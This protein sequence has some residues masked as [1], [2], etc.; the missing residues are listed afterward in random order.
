MEIAVQLE[1]QQKDAGA[2]QCT[3]RGARE[4]S[5]VLRILPYQPEHPRHDHQSRELSELHADV[6]CQNAGDEALFRK[7]ELLQSGGKPESVNKAEPKHHGESV[8][9]ADADSFTEAVEIVEAL[10]DHRQGDHSVD[11][12]VVGL[13]GEEGCAEQ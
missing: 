12:V 7:L 5:E 3:V 2:H 8:R 9:R 1:K 13:D 6:E 10:V 11:E 4:R